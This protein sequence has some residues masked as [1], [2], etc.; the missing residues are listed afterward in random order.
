[1]W[2]RA[3][4]NQRLAA[5]A[6]TEMTMDATTRWAKFQMEKRAIEAKRMTPAKKQAAIAALKKRLGM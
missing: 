5:A 4:C 1:M 2:F 3:I 6:A